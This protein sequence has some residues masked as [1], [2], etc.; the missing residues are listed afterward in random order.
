MV[1]RLRGPKAK[2]I[3]EAAADELR[4]NAHKYAI[5]DLEW[6]LN[7]LGGAAKRYSGTY[8]AAREKAEKAISRHAGKHRYEFVRVD[9]A[10]PWFMELRPK[11]S[12]ERVWNKHAEYCATIADVEAAKTAMGH[13]LITAMF[14]HSLR[15]PTREQVRSALRKGDCRLIVTNE[16]AGDAAVTT[17]LSNQPVHGHGYEKGVKIAKRHKLRLM[18]L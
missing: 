16:G 8:V 4:G 9:G 5:G 12:A 10:G 1:I 13:K 17:V 14:S 3:L 2:K 18:D 6:N 11:K 7:D 15:Y